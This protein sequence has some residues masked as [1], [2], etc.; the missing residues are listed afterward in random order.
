M[1]A[2]GVD[3]GSGLALQ[4]VFVPERGEGDLLGAVNAERITV[5]DQE[6][7]E[8]L[9]ADQ[10]IDQVDVRLLDLTDI[11]ATQQAEQGI[12]MRELVEFWKQGAQV[13]FEHRPGDFPIGGPP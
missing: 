3:F 6:A 11:D 12:G 9:I 2:V 13:V 10:P 5:I 8:L 1:L 7:G 4:Q